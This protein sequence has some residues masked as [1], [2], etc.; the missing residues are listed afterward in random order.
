MTVIHVIR[1]YGPV[2]IDDIARLSFL[3]RRECE[4]AIEELRLAGEPIVAG[5]DGLRLV[6]DPDLLEKYVQARRRRML[7]EWKGTQSLK[8]T[9]RAMR[10]A[11]DERMGLTLGLVS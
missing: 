1:S 4:K 3:S 2:T 8:R 10:E 6:E 9:L 5:N 7:S 11:Q